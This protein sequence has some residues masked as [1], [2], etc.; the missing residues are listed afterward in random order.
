MLKP[1]ATERMVSLE[2]TA[3][4][5]IVRDGAVQTTSPQEKIELPED[6]SLADFFII[7]Q[8]M[9][10]DSGAIII[11]TSAEKPKHAGKPQRVWKPEVHIKKG[12]A[13][14]TGN[15]KAAGEAQNPDPEEAA[16][17]VMNLDSGL[18]LFLVFLKKLAE[19]NGIDR[20]EL[21]LVTD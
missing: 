19:M 11:P 7:L 14:V 4:G 9:L 2:S 13:I 15:S 3:Q 18:K 16:H 20:I 17:M 1:T 6:T 5:V 10:A 12:T 8:R 21:S